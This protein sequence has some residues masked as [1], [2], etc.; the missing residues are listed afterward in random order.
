[1]RHGLASGEQYLPWDLV[2]LWSLVWSLKWRGG[3]PVYQRPD[4]RKS[5]HISIWRQACLL[6]LGLSYWEILIDPLF[7]PMP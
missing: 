7:L 5:R 3:G 2:A 6:E 4:R 1:M